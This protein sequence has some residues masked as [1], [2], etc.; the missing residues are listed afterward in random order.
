MNRVEF[1]KLI[2]DARRERIDRYVV[3]VLISKGDFVLVVKRRAD[4]FMGGLHELPGGGVA[5][6]E[7]IRD[8]VIRETLEETG[9]RITTIKEYLGHFDYRSETGEVN[10]QFNF[11]AGSRNHTIQLSDEHAEYAWITRSTVDKYFRPDDPVKAAIMHF[12][13]RRDRMREK[14]KQ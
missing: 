13:D 5:S 6:G 4:D 9:L 1:E 10:R 2:G 12:W 3:G 8:A 7:S 14:L 11:W